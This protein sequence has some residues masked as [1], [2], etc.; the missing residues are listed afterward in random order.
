MPTPSRRAVEYSC[1]RIDAWLVVAATRN[2]TC[3]EMREEW[4]ES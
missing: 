3:L 2:P 1:K 4:F